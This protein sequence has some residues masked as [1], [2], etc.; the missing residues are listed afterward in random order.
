MTA[1][2]KLAEAKDT[3]HTLVVKQNSLEEYSDD[4]VKI[5]RRLD[6]IRDYIRDLER[7]VGAENAATNGTTSEVRFGC[8]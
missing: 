8:P 3:R 4:H 7:E 2:E 6:A 5:T 1:A